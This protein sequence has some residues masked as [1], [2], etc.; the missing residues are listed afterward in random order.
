MYTTF[1]KN[2]QRLHRHKRI[3]GKISGTSTCP[4]ISIFKSN[5]YVYAS[6]IDDTNKKTLAYVTSANLNLEN[7][8][9]VAAGS[10]V[11]EKLAQEA[12]KLNIKT[13][14]FDRSGYIYHGVVKAI[15][16][17]CRKGGLTF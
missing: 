12:K 13:A 9:N 8:S 14:V 15:A 11:G 7:T 17:S 10:A 6:L 4:R 3:R 16:D 1:D 2:S 5:R